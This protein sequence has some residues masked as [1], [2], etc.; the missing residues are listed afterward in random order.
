[1]ATQHGTSQMKLSKV[2]ALAFV[3]IATVLQAQDFP[4]RP[5]RFIVPAPPGGAPDAVARIISQRM[6]TQ[7][8]QQVIVD[9]R[10]GGNGIIGSEAG[11]RAA[12]DGYT[13]V[14]GY[15]GP[16]S[17]NP[18]LVPNLSYD[19]IKDFTPLTLLAISQ[20]VLVVH[21]SFPARSVKDLISLAKA[22]PGKINY[23]SGG[24]GQS[25]HL[26]MEL[27]LQMAGAKMTHIPYKGAGPALADTISG[28][29]P[30]HFL[31]LAPAIPLIKSGKLIAIGVTGSS[32]SQALPE[33]PTIAESGLTGYEVLTW[34]GALVPSSTPKA[35][36]TKLHTEMVAAL[37]TPEVVEFYKRQ[38][39]EPGGNSSEAFGTYL[40]V[41]IEKW[42][43][44]IK[45]RGIKSE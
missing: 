1:M 10:G 7:L 22:Q 26:S 41:E 23:A 25:S 42:K 17:I 28:H 37:K 11:A 18:G 34:Y 6:T 31:A 15:A 9:N 13:I 8:G 44:L 27:L 33:V 30:L 14:M 38:G 16:F 32:R 5:I 2:L 29:V 43:Q 21:P 19:V 20:N 3:L 45:D 36:V 24:T 12:G 39:L 40:Q 4:S 35:I